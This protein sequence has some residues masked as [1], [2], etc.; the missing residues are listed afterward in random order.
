MLKKYPIHYSDP[1]K[2]FF[3]AKNIRSIITIQKKS[4]FSAK[5]RDLIVPT[6]NKVLVQLLPGLPDFS[7]Y[8]IPKRKNIYHTTGKIY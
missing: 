1:K 4:F 5:N 8:N 2:L 6:E 3:S 7:W